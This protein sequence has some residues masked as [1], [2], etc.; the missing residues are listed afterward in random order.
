[1]SD[2]QA[3]DV[4][5]AFDLPVN[6]AK[7][8]T[9]YLQANPIA[10]FFITLL[11]FFVML[12]VIAVPISALFDIQIFPG[13]LPHA[14]SL[15]RGLDLDLKDL[16]N[17]VT[18]SQAV[19]DFLDEPL[20]RFI[21][22]IFGHRHKRE[23]RTVGS[24][25]SSVGRALQPVLTIL[26]YDNAF[27]AVQVPTTVCRERLMCYVHSQVA[28]LPNYLVQAYSWI[29]PQMQHEQTYNN[30]ILTGLSGG[31]CEETTK[32]CP[33]DVLQMISFIPFLQS[34]GKG[35]QNNEL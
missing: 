9:G 1:M 14:R 35:I 6:L 15:G 25:I 28:K 10:G 18:G 4:V 8:G 30:A 23:V 17:Q 13:L 21:D 2:A 11:A 29:G 32:D 12:A 3:V 33:Y 31:D 5:L 16:V 19:L 22:R 7:I 34:K 24:A 20:N 27:V 26:D